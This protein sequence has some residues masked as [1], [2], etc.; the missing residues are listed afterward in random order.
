VLAMLAARRERSV[1][2]ATL[3]A[4]RLDL[5]TAAPPRTR[6]P[7]T[8]RQHPRSRT[9]RPTPLPFR[10]FQR[11]VGGQLRTRQPV[12]PTRRVARGGYRWTCGGSPCRPTS[13]PRATTRS[14]WRA[15]YRSTELLGGDVTFVLGSSGHVDG[16][17]HP[18]AATDGR[19]GP[20][21]R[22]RS[23]RRLAGARRRAIRGWWPHW[24]A[25]LA[26]Y[27]GAARTAPASLGSNTHPP[28]GAAPGG[29]VLGVD[30]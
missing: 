5:P 27:A 17:V 9:G 25:W 13:S 11:V 19:P 1:A 2:S 21:P 10:V 12:A 8:F 20:T 28:L 23:C 4:T 29:Y 6:R 18:P 14:P 22:H 24:A 7:P 16:V 26:P 15:A 30:G 3:L